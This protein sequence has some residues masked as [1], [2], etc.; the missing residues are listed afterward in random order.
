MAAEGARSRGLQAD[1]KAK[2]TRAFARWLTFLDSIGITN[3][4]FLTAFLP[5][6]R[7]RIVG[8]F[9]HS[10]RT[11][12][13][14]GHRTHPLAASTVRDTISALSA[15]FTE[16]DR[17]D[18]VLNTQGKTHRILH[19]QFA[20]YKQDDPPQKIQRALTLDFITQVF[21]EQ[22]TP[23]DRCFG[24]LLILAF[25]FAMRSCEYLTVSGPRK[26][27]LLRVRD[28]QFFRNRI[29]ISSDTNQ[30]HTADVVCITFQDQKNGEKAD[31]ITLHRTPDP[32]TC[33]VKQAA[34]IVASIRIIPGCTSDTPINTYQSKGRTYRLSS[35]TALQRLRSRATSLG[36]TVLGHTAADI[37]LHSCRSAAAMAMVLAGTP[38][39]VIMLIGRWKSNA[40]LRYIRKQVAEFSNDVSNNMIRIRSFFHPNPTPATL[41]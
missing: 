4:A 8:A 2:H 30:L 15:A 23:A 29:D 11:A 17:D 13:Y 14:S 9:A 34:T 37:G 26:T 22:H 35:Q 24:P 1:S 20:A 40:F 12:E 33:P 31:T 27:K 38:V 5:H 6:Q 7:T 19:L 25:F 21:A 32:I 3:D 18:P 41:E 36:P 10:V 16:H 39:Y 28:L